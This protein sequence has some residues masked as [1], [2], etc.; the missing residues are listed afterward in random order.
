LKKKRKEKSH[1]ISEKWFRFYQ[2]KDMSISELD[3]WMTEVIK[4]VK[5][6]KISTE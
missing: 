6:L 5:K 2:E 3:Q 1:N 4:D